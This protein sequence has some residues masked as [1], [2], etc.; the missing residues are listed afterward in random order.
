MDFL[1]TAYE[2]LRQAG[3]PLH[4]IEITRRGQ[5]AGILDSKG[6]TPEASMGSR[7]YV[8]TKRPSSRFRRVT[9]GIDVGHHQ[10][11]QRLG[12]PEHGRHFGGGAPI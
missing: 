5:T 1:D 2:I 8:D 3:K 9:G 4:Y 12:L 6:Q 11:T 10:E 7:L